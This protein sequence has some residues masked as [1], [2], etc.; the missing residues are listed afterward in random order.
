MP[1]NFDDAKGQVKE[2]AGKLTDDHSLENEGK[3]DQASGK[4]KGAVDGV[5]DKVQ[6]IIS[7]DR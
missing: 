1:E 3:V 6:E 5:K 2:K 4:A 7:D